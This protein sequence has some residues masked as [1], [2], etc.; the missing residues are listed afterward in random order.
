MKT[1]IKQIEIDGVKVW[2]W[3]ITNGKSFLFGGYC[4]TKEDAENDASKT[5]QANQ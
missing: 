3:V 5:I 1:T 2:E 4:A